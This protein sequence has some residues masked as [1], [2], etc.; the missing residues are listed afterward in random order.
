MATAVPP[1]VGTSHDPV[2]VLIIGAG[3]GG[4]LTAKT[5]AEAGLKV[6]CLEQA[7]GPDQRTIPTPIPTGSGSEQP[8]GARRRMSA[9]APRTIRSR[10]PTS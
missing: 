8:A 5:L 10:A 2:D 7:A 6:V 3:L 1:R 4:A 9:V